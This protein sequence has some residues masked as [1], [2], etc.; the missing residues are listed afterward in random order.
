MPNFVIFTTKRIL[1]SLIMEI[2]M[3]VILEWRNY[4]WTEKGNFA[5]AKNLL[6]YL[7]NYWREVSE[8]D[9]FLNGCISD[10]PETESAKYALCTLNV[11]R[12]NNLNR[13]IFAQNNINSISIKPDILASQVKGN[14]D[15]IMISKTKLDDTFLVEQFDLEGFIANSSE[16]IARKIGVASCSLFVKTHQQDLFL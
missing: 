7:E 9:L 15:V 6:K 3:K 2:L 13:L 5:L 10:S 12:K 4:I 14:A 8:S 16:L 1:V 11:I